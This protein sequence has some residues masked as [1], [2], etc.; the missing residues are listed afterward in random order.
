MQRNLICHARTFFQHITRYLRVR[1]I[2][3]YSLVAFDIDGTIAESKA[4]VD[5]EMARL[6]CDL[7]RMRNVA[8]V[9][10]GSYTQMSEQVI[11]RL[12]YKEHIEHMWLTPVSGA[13][14]YAYRNGGWVCLDD[15]ILTSE[16]DA[17][18]RSAFTEVFE[19]ER[20]HVPDILYGDMI[21]NRG[22]QMTFSALGQHAPVS[23]K[24]RWNETSDVRPKL[25]RLLRE[26]L[27]EYEVRL[28]GMT[29]IDIT[30]KGIDKAFA[31]SNLSRVSGIVINDMI[32]VGDALY[33]G[34]ND[35]AVKKSGIRTIPVGSV[36][37]TKK[38]IQ[39]ILSRVCDDKK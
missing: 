33:A 16:E 35:E 5:E 3:T 36:D 21:E 11:A 27:P 13:L 12:P 22:G 8:L 26:K 9:S 2:E 37:D 31:I 15:H 14:L 20:Y 34:G 18:I 29:S 32:Y 1:T 17:R 38:L 24:K 6:L 4:P 25:A 23:E 28:G 10:G 7:L 39:D 30:K 19:E